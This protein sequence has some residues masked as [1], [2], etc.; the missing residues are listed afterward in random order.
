V[1]ALEDL[2]NLAS[3]LENSAVKD[4]KSQGKKVVGF[5]CT[6][7]PEEILYAA[8]ILPYR[9][10][11]TGCT[12]TSSGDV[13]MSHLNCS[14]ARSCL[15]FALEDRYSFL[16]G[17]VY[18]NSCDD[19]RRM[20][21]NLRTVAPEKFAF[22]DFIDVPKKV[23]DAAIDWY[24]NGLVG[25]KSN[26]EKAFGVTITD[27]KLKKAI[28]VYNETRS[29]LKQLYEL[30]QM[31]H[32][33]ITGAETLKVILAAGSIP[34]D[35]FN[36]LMKALLEELKGKKGI[37]GYRARLMIAGAGGCDDPEYFKIIEDLGGLIVTDADCFGSRYFWQP[38][39]I[40]DDLMLSLARA[41]MDRPTCARMMN[42]LDERLDFLKDMI[43]DHKVDGV[44]YQ[45]I[46]YCQVWGGQ[47]LAVR[48]ELNKAGVP[49]MYL[50]REY[51]LGGTGQ[52]KTRIQAFL[53]T[54]ER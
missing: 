13:Y 34:K 51:A 29:L 35:R 53:E 6:Y 38:V 50:D 9:V 12:D 47:L 3:D 27:E 30:R 22:M 7:V 40:G 4:W 44:I 26:V 52:L 8:D 41:Y 20:Y 11:A 43:A 45:I 25:F 36:E 18:T 21:D 42:R 15:S 46:R 54:I 14:F 39:E 33:P 23:D 48:D 19:V 2:T 1:S 5:F 32:P 16:D 10:R 31:D 37:S 24:R 28:E 17:L 49:F